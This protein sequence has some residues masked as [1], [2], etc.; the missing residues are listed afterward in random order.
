MKK[1]LILNEENSDR[2]RTEVLSRLPPIPAVIKYYD[3][4]TERYHSIEKVSERED[5][6]LTYGGFDMTLR[7]AYAI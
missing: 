4:F 7:L 1:H 2:L 3:E 5:L 6:D